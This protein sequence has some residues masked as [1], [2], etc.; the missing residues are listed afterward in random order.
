MIDL[1]SH[2]QPHSHMGLVVFT[3]I[4]STS[5]GQESEKVCVE[6]GNGG[7]GH[8]SYYCKVKWCRK[9]VHSSETG[10]GRS[11]FEPL[12]PALE[13]GSGSVCGIER[14]HVCMHSIIVLV[15]I[16]AVLDAITFLRLLVLIFCVRDVP[17]WVVQYRL[18][19]MHFQL[20]KNKEHALISLMLAVFR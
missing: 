13:W 1:S 6:K 11:V 3:E 9:R 4:L 16:F 20:R 18:G 12:F 5:R 2:T 19:F 17:L 10:P 15:V 7:T 8:S 14:V